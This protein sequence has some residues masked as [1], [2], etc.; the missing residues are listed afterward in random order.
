MKNI[1]HYVKHWKDYDV[2]CKQAGAVTGTKVATA[3]NCKKCLKKIKQLTKA[4]I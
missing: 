3:V 1:V 2:A 4:G